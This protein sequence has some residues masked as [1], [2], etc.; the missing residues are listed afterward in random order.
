MTFE[1]EADLPPP[2]QSE[3]QMYGAFWG[4]PKRKEEPSHAEAEEQTQNKHPKLQID[5]KSSA[6]APKRS[7]KPGK[8]Q[9]HNAQKDRSK[10]SSGHNPKMDQMFIMMVRLLLRHEDALA[11]SRADQGYCLFLR[12]AETPETIVRPLFL[13]A[14]EW[15]RQRQD[16]PTDRRQ[17]LRVI[18]LSLVIQELCDRIQKIVNDPDL[19]EQAKANQMVVLQQDKPYW[20]YLGYDVR[21]NKETVDADTPPMEHDRVVRRLQ[22]LRQSCTADMILRFHSHRPLEEKM[23]KDVVL[24]VLEVST[25]SKDAH[26]MHSQLRDLCHNAV[27]K[28]IGGRLRRERIQRSPLA[29]KLAELLD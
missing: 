3:L 28:L 9:G 6:P 2:S 23:D 1:M 17:P 12:T 5:A 11:L 29:I 16:A 7:A 22:D 13:T 10:P 26:I 4:P 21:N 18:L 8:G 15:K 27:F 20:N 19:L 25:T 24:M 14:Q